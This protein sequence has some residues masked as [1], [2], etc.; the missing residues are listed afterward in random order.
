[1]LIIFSRLSF[2]YDLHPA[3]SFPFMLGFT[4]FFTEL[5]FVVIQSLTLK[6]IYVRHCSRTAQ[7]IFPSKLVNP[8]CRIIT[9]RYP[10]LFVLG[11][12]HLVFGFEMTLRSLKKVPFTRRSKWATVICWVV[13]V[14]LLIVTWSTTRFHPA[15]R[16][17]FGDLM[18]RVFKDAKTAVFV[19]TVLFFAMLIMA[20]IIGFQLRNHKDVHIDERIA[21]SR[22]FY[23]LIGTAILQ[24]FILPFFIQAI[25]MSFDSN[26]SSAQVAE[27]ILFSQGSILAIIHLVLRANAGRFA[28]MPKETPWQKKRQFRLFGPSDLEI[29]TIS[30]P[31][32]L[33]N[34]AYEIDE[35]D[36]DASAP[37]AAPRSIS[38]PPI[39]TVP[40]PRLRSPNWPR[41]DDGLP[42][43]RRRLAFP[44]SKTTASS[45]AIDHKRRPSY[46]LFPA[47]EDPKVPSTAHALPSSARRPSTAVSTRSAETLPKTRFSPILEPKTSMETLLPSTKYTPTVSTTKFEHALLPSTTYSPNSISHAPAKPPSP[48]FS[49]TETLTDHANT[50]EAITLTSVAD[51][52][53]QPRPRTPARHGHRR[54]SSADSSATVQIGLRLSS[55]PAAMLS[56]GGPGNVSPPPA[57]PPL[58]LHIRPQTPNHHRSSSVPSRP[59][60]LPSTPRPQRRERSE[61]PPRLWDSATQSWLGVMQRLDSQRGRGVSPA[62]PPLHITPRPSVGRLQTSDAA[63]RSRT[64]SLDT[65]S[66][67][68]AQRMYTPPPTKSDGRYDFF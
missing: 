23:Y 52:R 66:I 60:F 1:M 15:E 8:V 28:L 65:T 49:D 63:V 5:I 21:G 56:N 6:T 19:I 14:V 9:D 59:Q 54:G 68:S 2:L 12:V 20:T 35:K 50:S 22:M 62:P 11:Y 3:E 53:A 47:E 61:E 36:A 10:A 67:S 41:A 29:I 45:S 38:P 40:N 32:D 43:P 44:T 55:A 33:V 48:T 39:A 26:N 17:C 37:K 4:A 13:V 57:L 25:M 18:W 7:V 30:A 24:V 16:K 51:V 27:F 42:S 58:P 34:D 31:L 64:A 46:S